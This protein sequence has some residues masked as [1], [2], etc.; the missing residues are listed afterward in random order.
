MNTGFTAVELLVGVSIILVVAAAAQSFFMT[1]LKSSVKGQDALDSTR[2]LGKILNLIRKDIA[3]AR[4]VE[5]SLVP[6]E[7]EA[8]LLF[9]DWESLTYAPDI[10]MVSSEGKVKYRFESA[11]NTDGSTNGHVVREITDHDDVVQESLK[12]GDGRIRKMEAARLE[13][14]QR[15][16]NASARTFRQNLL[17][18]RLQISSDDQRF[19]ARVFEQTAVFSSYAERSMW[20]RY[21]EP[22]TL[23]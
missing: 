13:V 12:I 2:T 1:G 8:G 7:K 20:N 10:T 5:T 23:P 15:P 16:A 22:G 4:Y 11:Q 9:T 3:S 14:E 21:F 6:T 17:I 18:V 19:P